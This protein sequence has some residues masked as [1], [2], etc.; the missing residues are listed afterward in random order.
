MATAG[1]RE[2]S[3]ELG[4]DRRIAEIDRDIDDLQ[5]NIETYNINRE[6][7][8]AALRDKKGRADI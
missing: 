1:M 5:K 3:A 8:I 6:T 4:R 2:M 7:E